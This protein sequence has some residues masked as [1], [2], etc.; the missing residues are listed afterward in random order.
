MRGSTCAIP[1]WMRGTGIRPATPPSPPYHQNQFG[2]TLGLPL[3]KNKLFYFGDLEANRISIAQTNILSVPTALMRKGNFTELLTP[4]LTGASGPILLYQPNSGGNGDPTNT[5]TVNRLS[6][7]GQLNVFCGP[8]MDSVAQAILN[9]YPAPNANNGKTYN[10]YT[11]NIVTHQNTVQWDQRLDWNLSQKDQS[12]FRYS[13][14]NAPATNTLP[15][16]PILDGSGFGSG[17]VSSLAEGAAFSETHI[18]SPRLANEFRFGYN[19]GVFS[20]L[21]PNSN[22]DISSQLGLGGVPFAGLAHNGGLPQGQVSGITTFGAVG[23]EPSVESQN[24]Y[25]LLDNVTATLG[26]HAFRFGISLQAIRFAANQPPSSRG[27]YNYTGQYTKNVANPTNTGYGVADFLA[28]QMNSTLISTDTTINDAQWYRSGYVQDDWRL[29]HTLTINLGLRYDYFQPY[30]ENAGRQAN[31]VPTSAL[32]I[33]TSSG[34]FQMPSKLQNIALPQGL[35]QLLTKDNLQVQY[36]GNAGL[37]TA[38]TKNF[39]P[40]VGFSYQATPRLVVHSGFGMFYGGLQAQGAT[41]LGN[42]APFQTSSNLPAPS[43]ALGACPS[44]GITLEKGLSQQLSAGIGNFISV[45][46]MEARDTFAHTPYTMDYNLAIQDAVTSNIVATVAYVGDASRHLSDDNNWNY[47]PVLLNPSN[48]VQPYLPFPDFGNIIDI[49]FVGISS[50]NSLQSKLQ[51]R[52]SH[53]LSYLATYTYSHGLDTATDAAGLESGVGGRD[54]RLIPVRDEYTNSAWDQRHRLTFNGNYDLP[55]GVGRTFLTKPGILNEI[56][57]GWSTSFTYV[58]Q[59]GQPFKVTPNV[60]GPSGYGTYRG[61]LIRN[62]AQGGGTPDP[63]LAY[64][65]SSSCP[66]Q[67]RNR[68]NWYNPCAFANP[69]PGKNI[70][71]LPANATPAQAAAVGATTEAEAIQYLGGRGEQIYAPGYQRGNLSM[72]KEFTTVHEQHIE[73]RADAFNLFNHPSWGKPATTNDSPSGGNITGPLTLQNNTPDAR[74]FQLAAK[75]V[76]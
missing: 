63:S 57:G 52:A 12:F 64:S 40:R 60:A 1:I 36:V 30:Q 44:D 8:Q 35:Q 51:M 61:N 28:N 31:I 59:T 3:L 27:T 24:V 50:Y 39:A 16:G 66:A 38:Q 67:V 18:F 71:A 34:L 62:P 47:A 76:F 41:N 15:L 68:T 2:A 13:Y 73:F 21:Q 43:C 55:F 10:N 70:P 56:A 20:F 9:L 19:W 23:F 5:S 72:F 53:G 49:N 7:N 65:A 14:L 17:I 69:L 22:T 6:C 58:I 32:G 25:Q 75:Y 4:S 26:K 54:P 33:G 46:N 11:I 45:P 37:L 74:F 48:S 42:N 29:F